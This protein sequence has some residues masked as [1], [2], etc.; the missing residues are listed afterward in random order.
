MKTMIAAMSQCSVFWAA[1]YS[2]GFGI[3]VPLALL[4][5]GLALLAPACDAVHLRASFTGA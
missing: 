2:D 5:N 1:L 3:A 4:R